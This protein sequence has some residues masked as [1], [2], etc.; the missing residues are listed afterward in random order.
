MVDL[1]R[2]ELFAKENSI[3]M[4]QP[5]RSAERIVSFQE[6]NCRLLY[7]VGQLGLGGFRAS[8]FC[9]TQAMDRKQY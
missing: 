2:P 9:L 6:M 4:K 3:G 7:L 8:P 1:I 5:Y